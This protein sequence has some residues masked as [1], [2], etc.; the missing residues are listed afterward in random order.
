VL[1]PLASYLTGS[2]LIPPASYLSEILIKILLASNL[3]ERFVIPLACSYG[4][5]LIPL[6]SYLTGSLL[7]S[8]VPLPGCM[9]T[10][11]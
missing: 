8:T 1:I 10:V 11:F 5:F 4:K 9:R 2:L 6:A 7:H 3:T